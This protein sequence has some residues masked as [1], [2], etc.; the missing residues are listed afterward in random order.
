MSTGTWHRTSC[1][2]TRR[3]GVDSSIPECCLPFLFPSYSLL[4]PGWDSHVIAWLI[5]DVPLLRVSVQRP[6]GCFPTLKAQATGLTRRI[7][8]AMCKGVWT[9]LCMSGGMDK[10]MYVWGHQ[11]TNTS[12]YR[13]APTLLSRP[14]RGTDLQRA[15]ARSEPSPPPSIPNTSGWVRP[16]ILFSSTPASI[17][18]QVL[19]RPQTRR[20]R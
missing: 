11:S 19:W 1:G 17:T 6:T 4:I 5:R 16:Y 3:W 20:L 10:A 2:V 15:S 13:L 18:H 12:P 8:A 14:A 7:N 9:K